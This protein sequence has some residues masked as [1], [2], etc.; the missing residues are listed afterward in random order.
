MLLNDRIGQA[1]A[2]V[3]RHHQQGRGDVHGLDNFKHIND[4]LGHQGDDQLLKSVARRL[5][6]C[7]RGEDTVSRQGGDDF[8]ALLSEVNQPEDVVTVARKILGAVA[9][10]HLIDQHDLRVTASIG[11]SIYPDDGLDAETIIKNADIA[12]YQA[13]EAGRHCFR[14]FEPAPH[15]PAVEMS[16]AMSEPI[17]HPSPT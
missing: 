12:M 16:P 17:G 10:P 1:I 3:R 9:E 13:K 11:I 4:S 7:V 15:A 14:L 6:A 8:V 5:V 2:V